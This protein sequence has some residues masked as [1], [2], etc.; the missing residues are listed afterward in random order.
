MTKN[1]TTQTVIFA[2]LCATAIVAGIWGFLSEGGAIPALIAAVLLLVAAQLLMFSTMS[3]RQEELPEA[4]EEINLRISWLDERLMHS[5]QPQIENQQPETYEQV[6]PDEHIVPE[7]VK[8]EPPKEYIE[9]RQTQETQYFKEPDHLPDYLDDKRLLLFLEPVVDLHSMNTAFYRAELV[10]EN[11]RVERVPTS[12]LSEAMVDEKHRAVLDMKL[13]SRLGPVIDRLA[14]KG[15]ISGV[16]CPIS[17]YSFSNEPFLEELTRYLKHYPELARVLVIEI[18]Q[19]NLAALSQEGMAGLAFLAQ[20]G[21]TFSLGGAGLES[22]DLE[23]LAS[24]GFRYLDLDYQDNK[25]RYG[26]DHLTGDGLATQLRDL[27]ANVGIQLIGSG[28]TKNRQHNAINHVIRFGRGIT[29]SGP[30]LVRSDFAVNSPKSQ[31]A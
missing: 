19:A 28:F 22:P 20:I 27:A 16:I 11:D 3:T 13:F 1:K 15:K 4:L 14:H 31:A 29:F 6:V 12:S 9:T 18:S 10:F 23:S 30:R 8:P 24:L 2:M 5:N 7:L 21:A 17:Q 26:L 25:G